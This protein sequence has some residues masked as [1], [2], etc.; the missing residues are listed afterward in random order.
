VELEQAVVEEIRA[1]SKHA[2]ET[3]HP[4][5][6]NLPACPYARNAW[7]MEKVG[8]VF[9]YSLEK[10]P[11]Y[12][13]VSRFPDQYDV[14]L[15]IDFEVSESSEDFHR[16]LDIF[17]DALAAGVFIDRDIW[18]MGFHPEDDGEEE[19]FNHDSFEALIDDV[20]TITFVQRLTKLEESA[21]I[22]RKKGY[23]DAYTKDPKYED[24]WDKRK[25]LYRRLKNAGT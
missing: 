23:Y 21:E 1:W 11:L 19:T 17:N 13:L 24:L 20:Y 15:L 12:D 6:N 3:P 25:L 5:F 10:K 9:N 22:L 18:V 4:F 16:Y 8:F 7:A 14:V 2:L